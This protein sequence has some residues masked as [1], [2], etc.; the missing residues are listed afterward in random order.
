MP[1]LG[2]LLSLLSSKDETQAEQAVKGLAVLGQ[3]AVPPLA[4][5]CA[6]EDPDMRWWALRALAAIDHPDCAAFII[7]ALHDEDEAVRGCAA[8]ALRER[9]APQ[10]VPV[11]AVLL[12]SPDRMLARLAADALIATGKPATPAL[13]DVIQHGAQPARLEAVR[14]LAAIGDQASISTLFKLLDEDSALMEFWANEGLERLGVGMSF[15]KPG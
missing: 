7:R 15:F 5:L 10:A 12:A 8:I 9:P 11:L 14:A 2:E 1:A 6:S 3:P 4:V 13:L